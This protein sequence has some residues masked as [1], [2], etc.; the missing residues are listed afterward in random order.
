MSN[1]SQSV[2]PRLSRDEMPEHM[3]EIWDKSMQRRGEAHFIESSAHTPDIFNW[4]MQRFYQ[5]LF[6]A[7]KVDKQFKELGRLRLSLE[8]GCKT[9]NQGNRIDA[10]EAGITETQIEQLQTAT[11]EYFSAAE[12]AVIQLAEEI[13]LTNNSGN[14]SAALYSSLKEHFDDGQIFELGMV[15]GLLAGMAKFMFVFDIVV[16]EDYCPFHDNTY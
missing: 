14:L 7:G 4:Y 16:K 13:A 1:V 5:E 6:Y 8:H 9:C 12:L 15:F 3:Q 2:F 10:L 11:K